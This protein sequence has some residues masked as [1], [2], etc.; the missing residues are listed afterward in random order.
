[1][2][3]KNI[4]SMAASQIGIKEQPANSNSVRIICPSCSYLGSNVIT[5]NTVVKPEKIVID[6]Y[7]KESD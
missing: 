7:A 3:A 5:A 6:Y 1:M 4:I 2:T